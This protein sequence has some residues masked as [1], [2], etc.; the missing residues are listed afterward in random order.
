MV[1]T[2]VCVKNVL[3]YLTEIP[4]NISERDDDEID[5]NYIFRISI[6]SNSV[7]FKARKQIY[8]C[9]T[10]EQILYSNPMSKIGVSIKKKK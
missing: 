9:E 3:L 7:S 10:L 6:R 1:T 2:H 8:V 4:K 5:K